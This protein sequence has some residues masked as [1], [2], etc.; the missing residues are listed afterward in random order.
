MN[1]RTKI[2]PYINWNEFLECY[3]KQIEHEYFNSPLRHAISLEQ[4]K[5]N[6]YNFYKSNEVFRN[7]L[8]DRWLRYNT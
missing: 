5:K 6:Y 4:C 3:E 2:K 8:A 1:H 7:E